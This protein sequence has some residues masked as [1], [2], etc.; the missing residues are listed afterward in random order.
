MVD[1]SPPRAR[2]GRIMA[3]PPWSDH[4]PE[5]S[6]HG[7]GTRSEHSPSGT[8][9]PKRLPGPTTRDPVR[10]CCTSSH[11]APWS[12]HSGGCAVPVPGL[13][14][15]TRPTTGRA[16]A[17]LAQSAVGVQR[18]Q[19]ESPMSG[20]PGRTALDGRTIS[21]GAA[22]P[23]VTMAVVMFSASLTSHPADAP[24]AGVGATWVVGS[25]CASFLTRAGALAGRSAC[26]NWT[27]SHPPSLGVGGS[28]GFLPLGWVGA[29][30]FFQIGRA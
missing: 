14:R 19:A 1:R 5:R 21:R 2:N 9:R 20:G 3:C 29:G 18:P 7:G 27:P 4:S 13:A 23:T 15:R 24:A 8:V 25:A 22:H 10:R 6:D 28:R 12:D 26:P 30:G 17:G 16:C 11:R